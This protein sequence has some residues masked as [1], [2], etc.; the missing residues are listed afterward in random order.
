MTGYRV[1]LDPA[2]EVVE[3]GADV[4]EATFSD[5]LQGGI[6]RV[7]VA[8]LTSTGDSCAATRTVLVVGPPSAPSDLVASASERRV[9]LTW[10][11]PADDGGAPIEGHRVE[12]A[13]S[14]GTTRQ[15]D[16]SAATLSHEFTDLVNGVTYEA[17]VASRNE[18]GFG[19][20]AVAAPVAPLATPEDAA[21][22]EPQA[23]ATPGGL[24]AEPL[25]GAADLAWDDVDGATDYVVAAS[26]GDHE[27]VVTGTSTRLR[28]S[29]WRRG[30]PSRT[31]SP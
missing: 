7:H 4:R 20:A 26:P 15:R 10:S 6:H 3:F 21:P 24:T 18:A 31:R 25:N 16:V 22:P 23:P 5:L 27:I 12:L 19:P 2:G 8:A 9:E 30:P 11:P 13:G 1:R 29:T 28:W 17:E 14:D